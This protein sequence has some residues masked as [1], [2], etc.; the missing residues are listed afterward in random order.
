MVI[1][2]WL[3]IVLLASSLSQFKLAGG[4]H[5]FLGGGLLLWSSNLINYTID[6]GF[7]SSPSGRLSFQPPGALGAPSPE[8]WTRHDDYES[9]WWSEGKES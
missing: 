6:G 7:Q 1:Y 2:C 8:S 4:G 5:R 9:F 3:G